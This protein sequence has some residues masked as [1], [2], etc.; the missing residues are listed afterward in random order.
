MASENYLNHPTF[1]LLYQICS[2]GDSKELFATLYAQRLFFL[3]A[4][5]ARGTR[6]EPIGRN[7]AR[8]LV[9]NRLRQLRRDASLQ[10]YNQLQQ[11]FKQTFL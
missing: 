8:M 1:G 9:D 6:F 2:F 5:D 4:F 10:E 7:E 11:V 3:V